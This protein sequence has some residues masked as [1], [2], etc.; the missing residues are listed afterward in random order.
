MVSG[1]EIGEG[2]EREKE[3]MDSLI[4]ETERVWK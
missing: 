4:V 1:R 2:K 3:R